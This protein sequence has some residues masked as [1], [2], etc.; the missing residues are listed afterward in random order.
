[1]V[2][3]W[4][5]LLLMLSELPNAAAM[6]GSSSRMRSCFSAMWSLRDLTCYVTQAPKS[7]PTI[8]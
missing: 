7:S 8:V 2:H 5:H 1:M 6:T 4:F 3:T